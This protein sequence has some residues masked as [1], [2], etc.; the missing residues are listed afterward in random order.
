MPGTIK[1]HGEPDAGEHHRNKKAQS[2][3]QQRLS[4]E[5]AQGPARKREPKNKPTQRSHKK[6]E[7]TAHNDAPACVLPRGICRST[8][9]VSDCHLHEEPLNFPRH[10]TNTQTWATQHKQT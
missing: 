5:A 3:R 4:K 9:I 6:K 1:H 8:S 10:Y 7:E 2:E